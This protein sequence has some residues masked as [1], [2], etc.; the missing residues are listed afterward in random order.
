MWLLLLPLLDVMWWSVI[1]GVLLRGNPALPLID[2]SPEERRMKVLL[3]IVL[4]LV[5]GFFALSLGRL[6]PW[7]GFL[8][9]VPA[10][11]VANVV[12]FRSIGW[13]SPMRV[14][15]VLLALC[16][17]HRFVQDKKDK[18]CAS[19]ALLWT[20]YA[21]TVVGELLVGIVLYYVAPLRGA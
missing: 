15:V 10:Y 2:G 16:F 20:I 6:S 8:L 21:A 17:L 11:L 7:A 3:T 13:V 18:P 1:V 5:P 9:A 12:F 4:P 19:E 14:V